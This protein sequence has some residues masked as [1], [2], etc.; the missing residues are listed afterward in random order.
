MTETTAVIEAPDE[1]VT[2]PEGPI[3]TPFKVTP[4]IIRAS[5][6]VV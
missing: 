6:K 1:T 5:V 2:L 4:V 3:A